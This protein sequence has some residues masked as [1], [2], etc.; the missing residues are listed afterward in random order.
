[1]GISEARK[2][3]PTKQRKAMLYKAVK[4]TLNA[5]DNMKKRGVESG[6][7]KKVDEEKKVEE[8]EEELKG[9]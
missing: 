6:G 9:R 1:M 8:V 3:K 7:W 2:S 5:L 4:G